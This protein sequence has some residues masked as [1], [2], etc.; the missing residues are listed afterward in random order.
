M[1][2]TV[3]IEL[4]TEVLSALK[5]APAEFVAEMR[6]AAAVKWYEMGT[7]SQSKGAEIAGLSRAEFL[8]ALARYQVSA[9]QYTVE[10]VAAELGHG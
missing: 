10:E 7:V 2:Q 4:P 3:L 9:C 8:N 6:I 5:R 1:T